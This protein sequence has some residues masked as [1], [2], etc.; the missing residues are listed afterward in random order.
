MGFLGLYVRRTGLDL[1]AW[2]SRRLA[3]GIALG[4]L[5]GIVLMQGVLARPATEKLSGAMLWWVLFWRGLIYGSVDGVLLFAFPWIVSWRAFDAEK[6]G[7][8][9]K[10]RAGAAAWVAILLLTTTYHLGHGDFRSK[11]IL[12]PN[13]G[14]SIG[15][16]PTLISA[17]PVASPIS[18]IFLH[19]TAVVYAPETELFLPPHR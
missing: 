11:R 10:V 4:L 16:L 9:R 15:A 14:S 3:L 7:W 17:N 19:V 12:Q 6:T 2:L 18:H 5:G 8:G 1:S 13:I